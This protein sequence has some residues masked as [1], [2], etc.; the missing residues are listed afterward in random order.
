MINIR[1]H[2]LAICISLSLNS[3]LYAS[4]VRNDIPYQIYRDFAENRGVFQPGA[5]NIPIYDKSGDLVGSLNAAAA[6]SVRVNQHKLDADLYRSRTE[7]DVGNIFTFG[8]V[9]Q[10]NVTGGYTVGGGLKGSKDFR[11]TL[12]YNF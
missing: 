8:E 9:V 10:L 1:L 4:T 2:S 3:P 5:L 12:K 6:E 11:A 7:L